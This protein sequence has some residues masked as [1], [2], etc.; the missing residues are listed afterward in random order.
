ME[1]GIPGPWQRGITGQL[2]G[3][4]FQARPPMC[5]STPGSPH[6]YGDS[7]QNTDPYSGERFAL[8]SGA[9]AARLPTRDST[10]TWTTT[11]C[12]ILYSRPSFPQC[13]LRFASFNPYSP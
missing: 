4:S 12:T 13:E 10:K 5:W 11:R 9:G 6:S 8:A 3:P 7:P 2:S 1:S